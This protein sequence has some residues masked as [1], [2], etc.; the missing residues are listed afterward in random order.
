MFERMLRTESDASH[1]GVAPVGWLLDTRAGIQASMYLTVCSAV[2][3]VALET[4]VW[5]RDLFMNTY[6]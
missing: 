6:T 4:E 1:L 2:N 5:L 3:I